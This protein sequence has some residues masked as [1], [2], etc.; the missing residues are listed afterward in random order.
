MSFKTQQTV[1]EGVTIG[2]DE[3]VGTRVEAVVV[4][5]VD[6]CPGGV[7]V[8]VVVVARVVGVVV[9]DGGCVEGEVVGVPARMEVTGEA[10]GVTH[11]RCCRG[12]AP[13]HRVAPGIE[14]LTSTSG[15]SV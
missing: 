13:H 8:P 5:V 4:G 1:M 2:V 3:E 6:G 15:L 7:G 14:G 10:G 11:L 9:V 12:L